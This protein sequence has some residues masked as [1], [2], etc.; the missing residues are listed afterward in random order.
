MTIFILILYTYTRSVPRFPFLFF[1][2]F[3][4]PSAFT[5]AIVSDLYLDSDPDPRVA[6]S[7]VSSAMPCHFMPSSRTGRDKTGRDAGRK[8]TLCM[9]S[10]TGLGVRAVVFQTDVLRVRRLDRSTAPSTAPSTS[11]LSSPP[12]HFLAPSW[13]SAVE[14]TSAAERTSAVEKD[15]RTQYQRYQHSTVAQTRLV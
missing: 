13:A 11:L 4:S 1:F 5:N 3:P 15:I 9:D 12:P 8:G 6:V 2:P 14:R 7:R 10:C